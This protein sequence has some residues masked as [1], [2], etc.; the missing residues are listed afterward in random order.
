MIGWWWD[1]TDNMANLLDSYDYEEEFEVDEYG[2]LRD[3][4]SE[5]KYE[6]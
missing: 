5:G 6:I 4:K 1:C 3:S 2:I